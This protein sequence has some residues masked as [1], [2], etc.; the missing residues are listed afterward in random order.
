MAVHGVAKRIFHTVVDRAAE[1]FPGKHL[2]HLF[3]LVVGEVSGVSGTP[4][5][6]Q[7]RKNSSARHGKPHKRDHNISKELH[8]QK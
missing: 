3:S 5:G 2:R 8:Q 7:V 1:T 4:P 6:T